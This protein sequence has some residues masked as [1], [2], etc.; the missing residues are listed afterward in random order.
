MKTTEMEKVASS[1]GAN[2][3]SSNFM[4][5]NQTNDH[6][7]PQQ[8]TGATKTSMQ[9]KHDHGQQN[10]KDRNQISGKS[11]VLS[12]ASHVEDKRKLFVGGLPTDSKFLSCLE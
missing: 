3:S 1:S 7:N 6:S 5:A 2:L 9:E 10:K 11:N 12:S 8:G 4:K